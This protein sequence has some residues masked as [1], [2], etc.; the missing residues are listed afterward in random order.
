MIARNEAE[1]KK[2]REQNKEQTVRR[3]TQIPSILAN[4]KTIANHL[5]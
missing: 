3:V 5:V 2:K 1:R 4:N